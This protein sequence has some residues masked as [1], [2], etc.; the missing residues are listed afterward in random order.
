MLGQPEQVCIIS[1]RLLSAILTKL[2]WSES[3]AARST[4]NRRRVSR[5]DHIRSIAAVK[6][7]D[8]GGENSNFI[9]VSTLQR[10]V[11]QAA[12]LDLSVTIKDLADILDVEGDMLN[13][14]GNFVITHDTNGRTLVRFEEDDEKSIDG[15]GIYQAPGA[16]IGSS[17]ANPH[18]GEIGSP[19]GS[20]FA[21]PFKA[22]VGPP[23][24]I[25]T[26]GLPSSGSEYV[27]R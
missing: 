9:E 17:I 5:L 18:P 2:G 7:R 23:P 25:A 12:P 20:G 19:A 27:V 16:P 15:G 11:E 24:G 13:G 6:C 10:A 21:H 4:F 22:A 3:D 1:S 26:N 14:G 8:L